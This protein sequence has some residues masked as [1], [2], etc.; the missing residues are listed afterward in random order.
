[1]YHQEY[2]VMHLC[3][4]CEATDYPCNCK[5]VKKL[6]LTEAKVLLPSLTHSSPSPTEVCPLS[7]VSKRW[8]TFSSYW[9]FSS[10]R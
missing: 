1:M 3:G 2:G 9:S 5:A 8:R 10:R 4:G 7:P 6:C